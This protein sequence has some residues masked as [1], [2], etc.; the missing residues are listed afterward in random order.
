MKISDSKRDEVLVIGFEGSL[1]AWDLLE[2]G[3]QLRSLIASAAS[4][5]VFDLSGV[6]DVDAGGMSLLRTVHSQLGERGLNLILAGAKGA[7]ADALREEKMSMQISMATTVDQ[8]V[9]MAAP[10]VEIDPSSLLE[11]LGGEEL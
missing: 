4:V 11:E 1:T 8:A 10:T 7:A 5:V 3:P 2:V 9:T 6:N